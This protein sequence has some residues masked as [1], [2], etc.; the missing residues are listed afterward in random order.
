M[1][2]LELL[3]GYTATYG[4]YYVDLDDPDLKRYPRLSAKWY[5]HFLHGKSMD[6]DITTKLDKNATYHSAA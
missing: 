3:G 2:L 5:S 1:D 4:L 6:L